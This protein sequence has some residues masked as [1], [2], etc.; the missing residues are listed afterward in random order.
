MLL[1]D[2][3]PIAAGTSPEQEQLS[4][5]LRGFLA[6]V[7]LDIGELKTS[8]EQLKV[9]Q[10]QVV[11]DNAAVAEQL[12]ATQEQMTRLVAKASERQPGPKI[13]TPS[14]R[15]IAT[16]TGKPLPKPLSPQA[17][18]QPSASVQGRPK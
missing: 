12:K 10:E 14:P 17:R 3:S 18:A 6:V 5:L 4:Q 15:S 8:I 1:A 16:K 13:S 2:S 11:R 9:E 7:E